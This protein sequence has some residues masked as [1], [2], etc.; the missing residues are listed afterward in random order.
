[1]FKITPNPPTED[2]SSV[3]SQLAIERAFAHYE[4][5]AGNSRDCR[6]EHEQL[7]TED[8]L[9]QIDEIL[10]SAS[11]TAYECADNLQGSNRKLALGVVHLVDLALSRVD[12]L[13]DKQV[14][15]A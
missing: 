12:N 1:M 3:A 7:N 5:P 8:V 4:L 14:P 6:C 2:L 13:L 15:L 9:A 10:Q 11:A